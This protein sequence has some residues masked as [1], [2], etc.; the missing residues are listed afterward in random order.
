[1]LVAQSCLTLCNPM[2]CSLPG[3][4]VHGILQARILEWVAIPFSRGVDPTQGSNS[5]L[6]HCRQILYCL[7]HWGSQRGQQRVAEN[8]GWVNL[9][10]GQERAAQRGLLAKMAQF[11]PHPV[12]I[13]LAMWFR[14]SSELETVS[15]SPFLNLGCFCDLLWLTECRG[16]D[17]Q[18]LDLKRLVASALFPWTL[19]SSCDSPASLLQDSRHVSQSPPWP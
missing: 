17:G 14:G 4:F 5:G 10:P 9:H 19:P 2:D 18:S 7:M 1:M 15:I 8:S 16:S 11:S 12:I 13:S 6:L 3:S